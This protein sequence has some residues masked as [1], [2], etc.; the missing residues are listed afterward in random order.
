MVYIVNNDFKKWVQKFLKLAHG[1]NHV[2]FVA[3]IH[4]TESS[5]EMERNLNVGIAYD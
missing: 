5:I 2:K 3:T 4:P 1:L